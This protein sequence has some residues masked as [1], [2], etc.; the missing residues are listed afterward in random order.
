MV[1]NLNIYEWCYKNISL[2]YIYICLEWHIKISFKRY[3]FL[4]I[5]LF[6]LCLIEQIESCIYFLISH[7][8]F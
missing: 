6:I 4:I 3:L 1:F 5:K 8:G 2:S 7:V